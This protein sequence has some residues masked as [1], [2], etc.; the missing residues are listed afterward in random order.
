MINQK[1]QTDAALVSNSSSPWLIASIGNF[2]VIKTQINQPIN[3]YECTISQETAREAM[4]GEKRN[5]RLMA[6]VTHK[7]RM[8][9]SQWKEKTHPAGV[10][11]N[12]LSGLWLSSSHLWFRA[13]SQKHSPRCLAHPHYTYSKCQ[14]WGVRVAQLTALLFNQCFSCASVWRFDGCRLHKP[15]YYW[16]SLSGS[17]VKSGASCSGMFFLILGDELL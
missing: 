14:G 15:N 1:K 11:E 3:T 2:F 10:S 9:D 5:R 17:K 16:N 4:S 7:A 6:T 8:S 12:T 13:E